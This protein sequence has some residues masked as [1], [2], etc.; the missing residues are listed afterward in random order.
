MVRSLLTRG[1]IPK[2]FWSEAVNWSIHILNISPT[3]AV[4]N[5]T[6]E[7]AWSGRKPAVDHFKIF[8]CIAYAYVPNEKRKKLDDKGEKCI[9]LGVSENRQQPT[10]VIFD[11][12]AEEKSQPNTTTSMPETSSN[13]TPTVAEILPTIVEATDAAAQS[14]QRVRKR[15]AWMKDYEVTGID[16]T[17]DPITHFALCSDCDPTTFESDVKESKWQKAMND[18]I[19]AIQK[20][21]TWELSKLPKGHKTIG[22]KRVFKTK[23]KENGEVDKYK[24]RLVAKGYKQEYGV[25]YTEVFA[26]VARHDTIR[27]VIALAAHN[28]W[29]IFQLDV[30]SAFLH[31]NLEEQVFVEQPPGYIKIGNEHKVYKLKKAFYGLKQAPCAW[32]SCIEAYF[33]KEDDLIFTGND[34]VMFEEFKKSMMVEFEMFDLGM[35]H[36]FL[37]IEVVQSANRIFISQKKYMENPTQMHLLAAKK[38]FRYLQGTRDFGLF[39]NKG[40]VSWSSK[41]QPIV[42]LSTTE[43][44]FVAA[45]ACGCQAIWL[46]RIFEDLHFK[47]EEATTIY[48]DNRDLT[49]ERVID[50]I[51]C[52]SEDQVADIFTKPLKVATFQKL[53]KLLSVGMLELKEEGCD[54][55]TASV[56]LV[57]PYDDESYRVFVGA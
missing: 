8:G 51:Y 7:E 35:M 28:S 1:R 3:F 41:K 55:L 57:K 20:N 13:T 56:K 47:Q 31:G 2:T 23:L 25:D 16:Q 17:E 37:G 53:R 42:T 15:P 14:L 11:N 48:C 29:P 43:A 12:D 45:T 40:A 44:E 4:Q 32:Y 5:M 30:K 26:P 10:P 46:R 49:K 39:Y 54:R 34:N 50:L 6:P 52:R 9:F 22:V 24:A 33:L 19:E 27:L 21:D 38:I 18:E 36:Y